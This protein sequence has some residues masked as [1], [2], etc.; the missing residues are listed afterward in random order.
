VQNG[1]VEGLNSTKE[2]NFVVTMQA[3]SWETNVKQM[4]CVFFAWRHGWAIFKSKN[5]N[6]ISKACT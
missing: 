2:Q 6:K 4:C 3:H 1:G 5:K